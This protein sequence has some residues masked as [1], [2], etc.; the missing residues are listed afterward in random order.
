MRGTKRFERR[1]TVPYFTVGTLKTVSGGNAVSYNSYA[2]V[3]CRHFKIKGITVQSI[4]NLAD[5][6]AASIK[7]AEAY[8]PA[9]ANGAYSLALPS[10]FVGKK[11]TYKLTVNGTLSG[12]MLYL[13]DGAS[14]VFSNLTPLCTSSGKPSTVSGST[15][16]HLV[17]T[18]VYTTDKESEDG[19][20]SEV[21][22][23]IIDF[24]SVCNLTV[25][26]EICPDFE[27]PVVSAGDRGVRVTFNINGASKTIPLPQK[28]ITNQ[29]L[30]F[31][32]LFTEYDELVIYAQKKRVIYKEGSIKLQ[33][34]GSEPWAINKKIAEASSGVFAYFDSLIPISEGYCQYFDYAPW[35]P[36][37]SRKNVF[38][39]FDGSK[40]AIK[41]E[42]NTV[43][44]SAYNVALGEIVS[45]LKN[46]YASGVGATVI[47]KRKVGIERDISGTAL[48]NTL[49]SQLPSYG[50]SG[51]FS[52]VG[53]Q[54]NPKLELAYYS[55]NEGDS[56]IL[57]LI[58][59]SED[60]GEISRAEHTL[61]K[62]SA[63]KLSAPEID[64][65]IPQTS[66]LWGAIKDNKTIIIKYKEK[67]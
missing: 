59:Q 55:L 47:A 18:N 67:I 34:S 19:V 39:V 6:Y 25:T 36:S 40:F 14:A 20:V 63:Y 56:V 27:A 9:G 37:T 64:G 30:T 11:L 10:S 35:L 60:G 28:A 26:S 13:S 16:T 32:M 44:A 33:L 3:P 4:L 54:L 61:R 42:R 51:Q 2:G 57:T 17:F 49:L 24:W 8:S 31:D 45:F 12:V 58:C 38:S 15:F 48:A 43:S 5:N 21:R 41:L 23:G 22:D 7:N 50:A 1:I 62:G 46:A 52:A 29:G 53:Y 65:Y 66:E